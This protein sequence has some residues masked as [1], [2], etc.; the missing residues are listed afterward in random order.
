M[1]GEGERRAVNPVNEN[2]DES[3]LRG[4]KLSNRPPFSSPFSFTDAT[5]AC[6]ERGCEV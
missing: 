5:V 2:G 3:G 1:F 6:M 4:E